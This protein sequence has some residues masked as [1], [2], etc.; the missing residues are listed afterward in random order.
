MCTKEE[1]REWERERERDREGECLPKER[2]K[3]RKE[4]RKKG[5]KEE[6]E[7]FENLTAHTPYHKQ[8]EGCHTLP[9]ARAMS[10]FRIHTPSRT[11]QLTPLRSQPQRVLDLMFPSE[12]WPC[13]IH[14]QIC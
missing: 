3:E 8:G 5:K 9:R 2:E 13:L 7:K 1:A 12:T 10:S 4:G 6:R 11:T 14:R